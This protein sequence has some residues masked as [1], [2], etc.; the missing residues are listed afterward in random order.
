MKKISLSDI[1]DL[2]RNA[3][4]QLLR[5]PLLVSG[6]VDDRPWP[7]TEAVYEDT[8]IVRVGEK[9]LQFDWSIDDEGVVTLSNQT[10]VER[11]YR[12]VAKCLW[13]KIGARNNQ[14]DKQR[15]TKIKEL[16]KT[17]LD[18]GEELDPGE[19]AE[20]VADAAAKAADL[21][22]VLDVLGGERMTIKAV[23]SDDGAWELDVLAA[24]YYGPEPGGKDVH[25][26]FFSPRTKF[27]EEKFKTPLVV[28]YHGMSPERRPMGIPEIIGDVT[29]SWKDTAGL[30]MRIVLDKTNDYAKRI[31]KS[32][33]AG[34][35][36]ASSG[37][38]GHLARVAKSTGEILIWPIAE[39]SLMD[40]DEGTRRPANA[41]AIAKP[42]IKAHF[43]QM[44]G[45]AGIE[46]LEGAVKGTGV[47][48]TGREVLEPD[49]QTI[50][51]TNLPQGGEGKTKMTPEEIKKLIAE[52][53]AAHDLAKA[54]AL[55]AEL[56]EKEKIEAA[57]KA[58][59][60]PLQK[61]IAEMQRLPFSGAP[62]VAKYGDTWKYD[63][64]SPAELALTIDCLKAA[65]ANYSPSMVKALALKCVTMKPGEEANYIKGAMKAAGLEPTE[66]AIKAATDP[67]NTGTSGAGAEWV[68][69]AYSNDIWSAV[70]APQ[71]IAGKI[72]EV[73]I[74]DGYSNEYFPVEDVDPTWYKVP[75]VSSSDGTMKIPAAT[76]PASQMGT[77][78]KQMTVAKMAAR[79]LYSGEME[80]DE[81]L[82]FAA[83]LKTQL[84]TSGG[85]MVEHLVIDGDTATSATTN[86]NDI[87]NGSTQ[88]ATNL[89][90]VL[91]GF[92]KL[93]LVTNTANSRS[94]SGGL[95][96]QD[97]LETLWLMGPAG[98]L[99]LA[100]P[101][102]CGFILDPNTLKA[103]MMLPEVLTKDVATAATIENGILTKIFNVP[104]LPSWFMH[105]KSTT[106]P[107]K[108][109]TSGKVDQTTQSNNT[110]GAILSVRFDQWKFGYKR[111]MKIET[112]RYA[113]ADA[114]EIV[115]TMRIG[116]TSRDNEA[117]AESYNVGV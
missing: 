54:E 48:S 76:I 81:L 10:E 41:Y 58:A 32:A 77:A 34:K 15:I 46:E 100:D 91:D 19:L 75:E 103:A 113:S 31:W 96:V 51:S 109:N 87:G 62:N 4:M 69:T 114:N 9:F 92:R 7:Y 23:G 8:L 88:T 65:K 102:K 68:G 45:T 57:I 37:S 6:G 78:R 93:A 26:E 36:F 56:A 101:T 73:I 38:I 2:L 98:L 35:A 12:P 24:P 18:I 50:K 89:H 27:Y 22:E 52:A 104:V 74:P 66:D 42:S 33:K 49:N 55:K 5:P 14:T 40:N 28:Y 105:Y 116:L 3:V 61:Q 117:A 63:N 80:E 94:A 1:L 25:K 108:A 86:I 72:P 64:Y 20:A 13:Y 112:S 71:S 11:T 29:K 110:T 21:P 16:A 82:P 17:I 111:R 95:S 67:A 90:L 60:E 53:L 83:Q 30:W 79:A 97:F 44:M 43:E 115:A 59:T 85:E 39:I 106:N 70:R 84:G 47:Q 107:R 99:A